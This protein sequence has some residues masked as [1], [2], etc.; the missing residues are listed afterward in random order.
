MKC[1]IPR[2]KIRSNDRLPKVADAW[3]HGHFK[4]EKRMVI[5]IDPH[6]TGMFD[7]HDL[8]YFKIYIMA[9]WNR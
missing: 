3:V 2:D 7:R 6:S 1:Q 5:N 9:F 4:R 8:R